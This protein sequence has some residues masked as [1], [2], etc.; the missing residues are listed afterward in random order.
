MKRFTLRL[1][2]AEYIKLKNYCEELQVS[3]ND[4]IRQLVREW[5]PS[6]QTREYVDTK[7]QEISKNTSK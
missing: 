2:D 5:S 6:I 7:T 1:T 3:M 4:T